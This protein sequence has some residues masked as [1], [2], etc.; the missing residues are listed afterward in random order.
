MPLESQSQ[1]HK[2]KV[3]D[4]GVGNGAQDA[5]QA[6]AAF[7]LEHLMATMPASCGK[8]VKPFSNCVFQS[9]KEQTPP[10]H[11]GLH[12]GVPVAPP[13]INHI[14]YLVTARHV[15]SE[16]DE[17]YGRNSLM[18][19]AAK[20]LWYYENEKSH[21]PNDIKNLTACKGNKYSENFGNWLAGAVGECLEI[22]KWL[23]TAGAGLY[24][25]YSGTSDWSYVKTFFDDP[26]DFHF[27]EEGADWARS[28]I[29]R[30]DSYLGRKTARVSARLVESVR[31]FKDFGNG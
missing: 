17:K 20:M 6:S 18:S 25:V 9:E 12:Y 11:E 10:A 8:S 3:A 19:F 15:S 1:S 22:P 13:G 7:S 26:R 28:S 16:Y 24:Q 5:V 2:L 29:N 30:I 21:A 14:D 4:G 31:D 23:L 27:I